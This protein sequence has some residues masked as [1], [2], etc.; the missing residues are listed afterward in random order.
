[1]TQL[2]ALIA[3][4]PKWL[5]Q[6]QSH[7]SRHPINNN[8]DADQQQRIFDQ[9]LCSDLRDVVVRSDNGN[10]NTAASKKLR[11]AVMESKRSGKSSVEL[12]LK[13]SSPLMVQME[14]VADVSLNAE[15]ML[16]GGY[17]NN[18]SSGN[19][20]GN[21][22]INN[23]SHRGNSGSY[24]NN[25]RT[26]RMLKMVLSD[27]HRC[28]IDSNNSTMSAMETTP[29]PHLSSASPPG[30]KLLLFD[31]LVIRHG[32]LQLS[33]RNT[34][35]LGGRIEEWETVA[36]EKREK[37][38]KLRGCGVDATVK[39]LIWCPEGGEGGADD[40]TFLLQFVFWLQF[41]LWFDCNE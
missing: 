41:F 1:M 39:A 22:A 23:N 18:N 20:N 30:L 7:L 29:I 16:Q 2:S 4:S 28:H 24:N 8:N 35:V 6:C 27:G 3:P 9:I 21:A 26:N 33:P 32:I 38:R 34:L 17:N 14:E 19:G 37:A 31:T 11:E 15:G 36:R 40:G 13:A 12:K 5:E 10:T 25:T